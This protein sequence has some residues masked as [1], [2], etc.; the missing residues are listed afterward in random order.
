MS[1]VRYAASLATIQTVDDL[2]E[3]VYARYVKK[4]SGEFELGEVTPEKIAP[5]DRRV[6]SKNGASDF[7]QA[8]DNHA[9]V[10][11]LDEGTKSA[12]E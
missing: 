2:V 10:V 6:L 9:P 12:V 11:V 1:A 3:R 4:W 5:P 7:P 8:A